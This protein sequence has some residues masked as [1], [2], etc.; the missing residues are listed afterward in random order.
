MNSFMKDGKMLVT[1]RIS[2]D[3]VK[4]KFG[5]TANIKKQIPIAFDVSNNK[6]F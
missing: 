4:S 3:R 1:L 6:T 2:I 5:N